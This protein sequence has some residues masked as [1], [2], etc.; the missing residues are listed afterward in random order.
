M[1]SFSTVAAP[2]V[3][4]HRLAA[5]SAVRTQVVA[6]S[7]V[8][9]TQVVPSFAAVASEDILA[10]AE[11]LA[12]LRAHLQA[13]VALADRQLDATRTSCESFPCSCPRV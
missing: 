6:S 5:A 13:A 4:V 10:L 2:S 7:A 11:Q 9:G 12:L 1:K 3:A 8:V